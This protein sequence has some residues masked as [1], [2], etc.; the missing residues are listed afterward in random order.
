MS[1]GGS[2]DPMELYV[3]FRGREANPEALLKREGL[4]A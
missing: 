1:S 4:A 3:E 2:Q